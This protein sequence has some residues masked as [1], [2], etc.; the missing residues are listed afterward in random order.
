MLIIPG[1]DY[2]IVAH[3]TFEPR[4]TLIPGGSW[5]TGRAAPAGVAWRPHGA[6]G[7]WCSRLAR[8]SLHALAGLT[9]SWR[10][11]RLEQCWKLICGA[12]PEGAELSISLLNMMS[13]L[14]SEQFDHITL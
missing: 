13:K 10:G 7:S 12:Q 1:Q 11:Q 9:P 3:I 14:L 4:R 2:R 8:G 5:V 6:F